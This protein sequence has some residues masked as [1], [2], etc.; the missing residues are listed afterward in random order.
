MK[1]IRKDTRGGG[2]GV[3]TG[4]GKGGEL[5]SFHASNSPSAIPRLHRPCVNR[6]TKLVSLKWIRF[7][8]SLLVNVHDLSFFFAIFH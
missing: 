8:F 7:F 6:L 4:T 3:K 1:N 5:N 2:E